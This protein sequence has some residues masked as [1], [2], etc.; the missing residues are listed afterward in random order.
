MCDCSK[1]KLK[2]TGNAKESVFIYGGFSNWKDSTRCFNKHETSVTHK[3]AIDVV[4]TIPKTCGGV[5][6]M[7]SATHV[8]EKRANQQYL[9]KL[10]Q[11]LARQGI[12]F[13]GDGDEK[14][15]N[16]LQLL[17]FRSTDDPSILSCL[18]RKTDKYT[19]PQ[20]QN[21][22]I[23][24]MALQILREITDLIQKAHYYTLMADEVTD[25]SNREQVAICMRW[26]DD[27]FQPHEDFMKLV[28][29][30]VIILRHLKHCIAS[31]ILNAW[32]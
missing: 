5:G 21:E 29:V 28:Q 17:L 30:M 12:A 18:Q 22:L 14:D 10:I 4:V 2:L 32:I 9:V 24:I 23:K 6:S 16:F 20:I 3:A 15:S 13:R 19:S 11:F 8:L 26:V 7:L 25:I 1:L 27:D 31:I